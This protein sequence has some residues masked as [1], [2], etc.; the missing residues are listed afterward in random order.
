MSSEIKTIL[1][2]D[3]SCDKKSADFLSSAITQNSLEGFDY[4]K[5]KQSLNELAKLKM[6]DVTAIQSAFATASTMGVTKTGLVN[7]AK[8]YLSV[9]MNEKSQ[10]DSALNNQIKQRVASKR[11]EVQKLQQ[12]IEEYQKKIVEI[13]AKITEFQ[14]RI[15]NADE[16]V[17]KAK[18]KIQ[19]TKNKF[20][21][22]FKAFTDAIESDIEQ[23]DQH[24]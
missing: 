1:G 8:H 16:E 17:E 20:E 11:E 18:A 22:T 3:Q 12:R 19:E 5:F 15:G 2:I 10:F 14:S 4:I 9:L 7:S 6:D 23:I 13:K 21:S 24:L